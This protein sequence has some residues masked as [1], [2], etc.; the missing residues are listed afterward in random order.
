MTREIGRLAVL[1]LALAVLASGASGCAKLKGKVQGLAEG[2]RIRGVVRDLTGD[3]LAGVS[4]IASGQAFRATTDAAGKYELEYSPGKFMVR[5]VKDGMA[6]EP[7]PFDLAELRAVMADPV[8]MIPIPR[9]DDPYVWIGGRIA[10]LTRREVERIQDPPV[11]GAA[12]N[13]RG[14][15]PFLEIHRVGLP[16]IKDA[17]K[18]AGKPRVLLRSR[19]GLMSTSAVNND[20]TITR[21]TRVGNEKMLAPALGPNSAV[22]VK[23]NMYVPDKDTGWRARGVPQDDPQV[24]VIDADEQPTSGFY[25]FHQGV[26]RSDRPTEFAAATREQLRVFLFEV[27]LPGYTQSPDRFPDRWVNAGGNEVEATCTVTSSS[28]LSAKYIPRLLRDGRMDTGWCEDAKG[29]GLGEWV[30]LEWSK[31]I[32]APGLWITP[33]WFRGRESWR[34][35]NRLREVRFETS[36]GESKIHTFTDEARPVEV[37]LKPGY[38][39]VKLTIVSVFPRELDKKDKDDDTCISEISPAKIPEQPLPP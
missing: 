34:K 1:A 26:L 2:P 32:E 9:D 13:P 15:K 27:E 24:F 39:W 30:R 23:I 6:A 3:P 19:R 20:W 7:L 4:V 38:T 21:L 35:N 25:A 31:G 5:F 16:A 18:V 10:G 8:T 12:P 22:M 33:G 29:P 36:T 17:P 14:A 28:I 37:P 11:V